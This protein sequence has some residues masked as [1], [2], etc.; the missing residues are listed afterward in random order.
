MRYMLQQLAVFLISLS[1]ALFSLTAAAGLPAFPG[2]EGGGAL[3]QGG[4]GGRVIYVTTLED[5]GDNR[6]PIPGSF[7][8]AVMSTGPRI[9]VFRVGGTIELKKNI[10]INSE[11]SFLT[12]AGQTAPGGG[13][14]ISGADIEGWIIDGE[15]SCRGRTPLVIYQAE[16]VVI[17]YLRVRAGRGRKD[18]RGGPDVISITSTSR[19]IM[20]D[21]LSL[22]WAQDE[23]FNVNA[24]TAGNPVSNVTLQN[25][26]L[27]EPVEGHAT[28]ALIGAR[29]AATR[30]KMFDIDLIRNYLVNSN[31]RN[32]ATDVET[33]RFINN[34]IYNGSIGGI[35]RSG[36]KHDII[37]NLYKM[38]P[39]GF[40]SSR[41]FDISTYG[42]D[43]WDHELAVRQ[44]PQLYVAGNKGRWY[45]TDPDG[46]NW[47]MVRH[48]VG[49]PHG[50]VTD[51]SI[52]G[53]APVEWRRDNPL[54]SPH[55]IP[56]RVLHADDLERALLPWVGAS[57]RLDCEG[58]WVANRDLQ[59]ERV[60]E[61]YFSNGGSLVRDEEDVGGFPNLASGTPCADTSGDGVADAWA[62]NNA[63]DYNDPGLGAR[64]H[65]TGYTYL[66][67]YLSG[68]QLGP[69]PAGP[70]TGVRVE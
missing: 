28:S 5:N 49:G 36:T 29:S 54:P 35:F 33:G 63:L 16:H 65:E 69:A 1:A 57:R 43:D 48:M 31:H 9:V 52:N 4:R 64:V 38:G 62:R 2:A 23:T 50:T 22:F 18:C 60:I 8:A 11:N 15:E 53:H 25:S 7:R 51:T 59:D 42:A 47:P 26:I 12:I 14:Q 13:I 66:E 56:I 21:H 39:I 70:P 67:L 44:D 40:S 68:M 19:D 37:G 45:V 24:F 41:R 55:G 32:P 20:L 27:A 58:N 61:Q 17:R 6:N 34:V 30:Q 46:D 10:Q 3:S